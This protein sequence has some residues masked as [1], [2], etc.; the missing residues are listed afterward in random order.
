MVVRHLDDFNAFDFLPDILPGVI[1]RNRILIRDHY[2]SERMIK[3]T[4]P[5]P[6]SIFSQLIV[7]AGQVTNIF[8]R[9]GGTQ[10]IKTLLEYLCPFRAEKANRQS[11]VVCTLTQLFVPKSYVHT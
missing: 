8:E 4:R 1:Q 10:I 2:E 11:I 9:F 3:I 5:L 7:M 6:F